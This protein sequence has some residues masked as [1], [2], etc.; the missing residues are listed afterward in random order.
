MSSKTQN[1]PRDNMINRKSHEIATKYS[2]AATISNVTTW[3][4]SGED[5]GRSTIKTHFLHSGIRAIIESGLGNF[6]SAFYENASFTSE[7]FGIMTGGTKRHGESFSKALGKPFQSD[8]FISPASSDLP[9]IVIS[10]KMPILSIAKNETNYVNTVLGES[11]QFFGSEENKHNFLVFFNIRQRKSYAKNKQN[12][13]IERP[14]Y[15]EVAR[16]DGFLHPDFKN[17]LS[18]IAYNRTRVV[19]IYFDWADDIDLSQFKNIEDFA[20]AIEQHDTFGVDIPSIE[21][22]GLSSLV[23]IIINSYKL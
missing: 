11:A 13:S 3:T 2:V 8:L 15:S 1:L 19:N 22:E 20:K 10:A 12:L 16:P 4:L 14:T 21:M 6:M 9:A 5:N 7:Q 18:D 17:S 23:E